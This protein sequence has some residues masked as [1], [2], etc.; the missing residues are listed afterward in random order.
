MVP[1]KRQYYQIFLSSQI[2]CWPLLFTGGAGGAGGARDAGG[3]GSDA[4]GLG[5]GLI[6]IVVSRQ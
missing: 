1:F 5:G 4:L 2:V 3:D 6:S